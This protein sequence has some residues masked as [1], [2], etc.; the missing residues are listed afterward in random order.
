MNLILLRTLFFSFGSNFFTSPN[1]S[2]LAVIVTY[3]L[4]KQIQTIKKDNCTLAVFVVL[5]CEKQW[6]YLFH[7]LYV[8]SIFLKSHLLF[9]RLCSAI[10]DKVQYDAVV[11]FLYVVCRGHLVHT[12]TV[13]FDRVIVLLVFRLFK[14]NYIA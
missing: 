2:K 10:N 4:A 13:T 8:A 7:F 12:F 1:H 6:Q 3:V 9:F 5:K 14:T 11:K